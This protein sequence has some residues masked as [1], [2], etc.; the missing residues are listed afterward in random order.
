[1]AG[2]QAAHRPARRG[3][4]PSCASCTATC[5]DRWVS[6]QCPAAWTRPSLRIGPPV[7]SGRSA[8]GEKY[9]NSVRPRASASAKPPNAAA[10]RRRKCSCGRTGSPWI[11]ASSRASRD[12]RRQPSPRA[13]ATPATSRSTT[14]SSDGTRTAHP[15][16]TQTSCHGSC[17]TN[18]SQVHPEATARPSRL[19]RRVGVW[20]GPKVPRRLRGRVAAPPGR[21]THR[22]D[23]LTPHATSAMRYESVPGLTAG[24]AANAQNR[25]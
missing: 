7:W 4:P 15:G 22:S 12:T 2:V 8:C 3:Y 11:H 10:L 16:T 17:R 20:R 21:R 6:R 14:S 13:C 5:W 23:Q 18:D 9:R 1:M 25:P 19:R 24:V